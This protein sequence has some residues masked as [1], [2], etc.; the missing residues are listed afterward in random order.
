MKFIC[1][2]CLDEQ[3]WERM[4]KDE[5]EALLNDC[6]TYDDSLRERGILLVAEGLQSIRTAKT[7]LSKDGKLLVTDGPFAE[8]KEQIGGLW[9]FEA[10]DMKH[11]IEIMAKHPAVQLGWPFEIRPVE[12]LTEMI[13]EIRERRR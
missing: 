5:Q 7:L 6:F 9:M 13:R 11:A 1:L 3:Q 2:G 8:T 10:K 4:P 12:D